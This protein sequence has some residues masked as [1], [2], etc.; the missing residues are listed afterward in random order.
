MSFNDIE[1][2]YSYRS[3]I[4]NLVEDFLLKVLN[5]SQ[6]YLR[7]TGY[8]SVELFNVLE[9]RIYPFIKNNGFI[10]IICGI[11][12]SE[13][14]IK[15]INEGYNL[16]ELIEK[17]II[18]E[19][20]YE[21]SLLPNI[22]WLIAN[23][24]LE[25]KIALT[26]NYGIYHEKFSIFR[27]LEKNYI[28]TT[29]SLNETSSGY[30]KNIEYI[31]VFKFG[32]DDNRIAEKLKFFEE[33]WENKTTGIKV[34]EFNEQLIKK[35]EKIASNGP[36]CYKEESNIKISDPKNKIILREYQ[37][38]AIESLKNNNWQGIFAMATGT[39]KTITALYALKDFLKQEKNGLIVI[40]C[41]YTHL[42]TQ[43]EK[44]ILKVF[45]HQKIIKCF[46]NRK[47]WEE[48]LSLLIRE[49]LLK[50][51]NRVCITTI[52]TGSS[53]RFL[54]LINS[55][56]IEKFLI[57]DEV[58][59]IGA[60]ESKKILSIDAIFRLGLSATPMRKYDEEGNQAIL[61]YFQKIV[62]EFSLKAAI[63]N[64]YL[65]NYEYNLFY[66]QLNDEEEKIYE[67]LTRKIVYLMNKNDKDEAKLEGLLLKRAKI[68]STCKEKLTQLNFL[69]QNKK[70][71]KIIFY[72]AE[73]KIFFDLT[74]K[75][76]EDNNLWVLKITASEKHER[77]TE[78]IKDL[79]NEKI[80]GILAM[81]C[82]DEG[83]DIPEVENA[84]ILASSTNE[85]QY[86]QRRGRILRKKNK[87]DKKIANIYDFIVIPQ[88]FIHEIEKNIFKR[89]LVRIKEFLSCAKNKNEIIL[90]LL[91]FSYEKVCMKEFIYLLE[92]RDGKN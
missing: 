56:K 9:K 25:I 50:N 11:D 85:K 38:E 89:E 14:D 58:H 52:S 7:A 44:E 32:R 26:N 29:G 71:K 88:K 87:E 74:R 33:L 46:E 19:E 35:Y 36:I 49:I 90:N 37:K 59:N 21:L 8:F 41:P 54:S 16:R 75:V 24:K 23:K 57:I 47:N 1:L 5:E 34:F 3:N 77:R 69:L 70:M 15:L 17:K 81:K 67:E 64:G 83:V 22:C 92:E 61:K 43:W 91:K 73:D 48:K 76:I 20:E 51:E 10:K 60:K 28:A 82:L 4:D 6:E 40:V 42:V 80:D 62:F 31:D 79:I 72:T 53:E 18:Q 12:L 84:V 68:L 78:I 30:Q 13:N 66:C 63:E 45:S 39:G 55:A 27:D 65:A 86:I 2:K